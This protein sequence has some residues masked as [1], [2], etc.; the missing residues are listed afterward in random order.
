VREH[1]ATEALI[2]LCDAAHWVF[3]AVSGVSGTHFTC[4]TGAKV[5]ALQKTKV[6]CVTLRIGS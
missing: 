6:R 3:N 1:N 4:F 2:T 5:L